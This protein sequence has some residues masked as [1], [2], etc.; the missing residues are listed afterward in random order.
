MT[1][2]SLAAAS[3]SLA[4]ALASLAT[5]A[6]AQSGYVRDGFLQEAAPRSDDAFYQS[7]FGFE[8][9]FFGFPNDQA[10]VCNNGYAI[11][12]GI[13]PNGATC[14]FAGPLSVSS[15]PTISSLR[16]FYGSVLVPF[17]ADVATNAGVGGQLWFGTGLVGQRPAWAATWDNVA[18]L[19][20]SAVGGFAT[21]QLVLID[22][23][24]GDF[25]FEYNYGAVTRLPTA[26][27]FADDGGTNGQPVVYN[28]PV[29]AGRGDT[30]LRGSFVG[31][32]LLGLPQLV[33]PEPGTV[34]LTATG[35]G[36]L[37]GAGARRRLRDCA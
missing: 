23:G 12:G 16:T 36:L 15:A 32:N 1:R 29:G 24:G 6:D 17:F 35:L 19:A 18:L 20:G 2:P 9:D 27:G 3:A 8:I 4:L 33:T 22:D 28:A 7:D 21:F 34:A 13:A 5:A 10:V 37:V 26:V 25:S 14:A 11:L 30:Q 31:G